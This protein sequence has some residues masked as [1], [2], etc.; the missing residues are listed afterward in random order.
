MPNG[1]ICGGAV[2]GS[3]QLG[4]IV[5]CQAMTACPDGAGSAARDGIE[6]HNNIATGSK[7]INARRAGRSSNK[8]I[9]ASL[10]TCRSLT[11]G[12]TF[13]R[14]PEMTLATSKLSCKPMPWARFDGFAGS[15]IWA[16]KNEA[17]SGLAAEFGEQL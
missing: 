7:P 13:V 2:D 3:N 10:K 4:A 16:P 9:R 14:V 8:V 6:R 11:A 17:G 1:V 5:T 12:K 15:G